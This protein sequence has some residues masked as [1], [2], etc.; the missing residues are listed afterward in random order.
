MIFKCLF[1]INIKRLRL[2]SARKE[3]KEWNKNCSAYSWN[4]LSDSEESCS[5]WENGWSCSNAAFTA[6]GD[7]ILL[8]RG[9]PAFRPTKRSSSRSCYAQGWICRN[10]WVRRGTEGWVASYNLNPGQLTAIFNRDISYFALNVGPMANLAKLL[11]N[12][13]FPGTR[14]PTGS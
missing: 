8:F 11:G 2:S 3:R 5:L 7:S 4:F 12:S 1:N 6:C 10:R 14:S 9:I 13:G